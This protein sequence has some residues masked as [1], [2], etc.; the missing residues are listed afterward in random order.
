MEE[1]EIFG[2]KIEKRNLKTKI[3][4][5]TE[6]RNTEPSYFKMLGKFR[7]DITVE[8]INR[9][10]KSAPVHVLGDMKE[11]LIRN[12]INSNTELSEFGIEAWL[13][14]DKNS[15]TD[16][17][18]QALQDWSDESKYKFFVLS[19]PNFEFWLLLHFYPSSDT[20]IVEEFKEKNFTGK[21]FTEC[22]KTHLRGYNRKKKY[23]NSRYFDKSR[24]QLAI[25]HARELDSPK[26][27]TWPR[28]KWVTTVYRL[29]DRILNG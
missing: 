15:W 18:L 27:R 13:V 2:R 21:K 14:T 5:S 7:P 8:I 16:N 25:V 1:S 19:N 22:L 9:D 29:T 12:G 26:S 3:V 17:Q 20:D 10:S 23:I 24:I 6:G 28:N 4:I 11:W